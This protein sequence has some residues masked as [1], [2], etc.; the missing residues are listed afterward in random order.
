MAK[1]I[2]ALTIIPLVEL[3]LLFAIGGKIGFLPTVGLTILT[4]VIGSALARRQAIEVWADWSESM[5]RLESPAHSV[6]E[7][8][9]ILV[10]GVLLLTPGFLTDAVGFALLIPWTR[11]IVLL[12]LRSAIERHLT[13]MRVVRFGQ[14]SFS[15]P[16]S[17][18]VETTAV[19]VPDSNP[20]LTPPHG[21]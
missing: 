21:S 1:L 8:L 6:L 16:S 12:P 7:G 13:K 2:L 3:Y 14:S 20:K 11:K 10:G 5:Q 15:R 18:V 4:A 9:L 17:G 19:E